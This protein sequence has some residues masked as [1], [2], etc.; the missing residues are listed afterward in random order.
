MSVDANGSIYIL[1]TDDSKVVK[2]TPGRS[3]LTIVAGGND[4]GDEINQLDEPY[5]MFVDPLTTVIWIADTNNHRIVQWTSPLT[6]VV[7]CGEYGSDDD[8][9][10]NP[11]DVF[12]DT[13]EANTLYVV[14]TNNHRIQL[15]RTGAT[16]G[17]TVAGITSYY[18]TGLNQLWL[19][20]AVMV[21][22]NRNM[23]IVDSGNNRILEWP[24][25]SSSGMII[26]GHGD[27]GIDADQLA[28]PN[29]IDFDSSGSLYVAD[30][31]NHRIQKFA[32]SCR[33]K[34]LLSHLRT[35]CSCFS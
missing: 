16:K 1:D 3:T 28:S 32:V 33:K 23:F 22:N 10:I 26:A 6:S 31:N 34:P 4:I 15:W 21:D 24:I 9:F 8:Q 7:V 14:D 27:E 11:Q 5:G 29:R 25:G 18:G 2:W 20:T 13:S 30:T 19:P 35:V 17:T 12:V